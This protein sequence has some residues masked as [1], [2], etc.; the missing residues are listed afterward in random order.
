LATHT[1]SAPQLQ[2]VVL[3]RAP[4]TAGAPAYVCDL[5]LRLDSL[6]QHSKYPYEGFRRVF[7][8]N[9]EEGKCLCGM[10]S[11]LFC[12]MIAKEQGHKEG[13]HFLKP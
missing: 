8:I 13:I 2:V 4:A 6:F 12:Q 11:L 7:F 3:C 1:Q 10:Q 5:F 9:K